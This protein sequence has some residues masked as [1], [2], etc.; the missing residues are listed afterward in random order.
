MRHEDGD[1]FRQAEVWCSPACV[2]WVADS[3]RKPDRPFIVVHLI[4]RLLLTKRQCDV[5]VRVMAA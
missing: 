1:G 5:D 3:D 2:D 4:L